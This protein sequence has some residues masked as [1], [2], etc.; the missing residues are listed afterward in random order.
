VKYEGSDLQEIVS[1][2]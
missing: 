2:F 1:R